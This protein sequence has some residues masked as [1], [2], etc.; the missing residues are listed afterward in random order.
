MANNFTWA[1]NMYFEQELNYWIVIGVVNIFLCFTAVFRNST[2]LITNWKT[3]SLHWVSNI[4]LASR[5]VSDLAVGLVVQP[6]FIA[7]LL[8]PRT[9]VFDTFGRSVVILSNLLCTASFITVSAIT[10]DRLLAF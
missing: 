4:L 3:S 2:I 8:G 10:V 7:N 6:L 5:A 9:T 1:S